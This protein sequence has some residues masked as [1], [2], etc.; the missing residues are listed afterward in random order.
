MTST[1]IQAILITAG[2]TTRI[3]LDPGRTGPS[4]ARAIGCDTFDV[5]G[6]EDGIDIY[7][8]DEGP[9]NGS[10]LNLALTIVAHRLGTPAVL[11]GSGVLVS[12]DDEGDTISL[13]PAQQETV[14][15]A[16][17][18]KP[19]PATIDRLCESLA[20]LPSVVALLRAID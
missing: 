1:P 19:D 13:T 18:D 17:R 12:T 15:T 3:A 8:D 20:P 11:F 5:V 9:I 14:L 16:L 10:P 4:I 6:L 2:I 7:V